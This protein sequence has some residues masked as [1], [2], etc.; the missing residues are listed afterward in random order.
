MTGR[1]FE[2]YLEKTVDKNWNHGDEHHFHQ[3]KSESSDFK[4]KVVNERRGQKF[5]QLGNGIVEFPSDESPKKWVHRKDDLQSSSFQSSRKKYLDQKLS[6]A[7]FNDANTRGN[8]MLGFEGARR[9]EG[10]DFPIAR[11]QV[12]DAI[13]N[14]MSTNDRKSYQKN[15]S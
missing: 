13:G 6:C 10:E 12:K 8:I 3:G 2:S 15:V 5:N 9:K 14:V 11:A 1:Q 4:I 7:D